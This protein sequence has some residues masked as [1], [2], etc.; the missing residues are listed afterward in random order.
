LPAST[1]TQLL[2]KEGEKETDLVGRSQ[3]IQKEKKEKEKKKANKKEWKAIFEKYN[4]QYCVC[5]GKK[6]KVV[7]GQQVFHFTCIIIN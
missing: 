2:T 7:G 3:T 6:T 4:E 1:T 5:M